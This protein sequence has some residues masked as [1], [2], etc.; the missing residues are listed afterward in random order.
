[1]C[2]GAFCEALSTIQYENLSFPTANALVIRL[3]K[4]S[5]DVASTT[6]VITKEK[7]VNFGR[8]LLQL[9]PAASSV[10]LRLFV[11]NEDKPSYKQFYD[12]LVSELY[13]VSVTTLDV[14]NRPDQVT[15]TLVSGV[16]LTL[17]LQDVSGL[18][19]ITHGPEISCAHF[20]HL[21]YLNASTLKTLG[22]SVAE[23]KN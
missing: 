4:A 23:E 19:S 20:A 15:P 9:T 11:A 16:P 17:S 22:I 8:S 3:S 1:M 14:Q 2:D 21:A 13:H 5:D 7:A 10:S 12:A 18:T 6:L